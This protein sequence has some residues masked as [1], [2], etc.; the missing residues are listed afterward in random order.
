MSQ[1]V[2]VDREAPPHIPQEQLRTGILA[3]AAGLMGFGLILFIAANWDAIG[4]FERFGLVG[5]VIAAGALAS[6]ASS[7]LRI[8]GLLLATAGAGG[9]LAL[10][11][12]TYQT[13]ADPWSL[14]ALWA[15]LSLPWAVAARTDALWTPWSLIAMTAI[16]LWYASFG[17]AD[18]GWFAPNP[19]NTS[20]NIAGVP[21]TVLASWLLSL[22][23]CA[24][25][26]PSSSL[27]NW[28]GSRRWAFRLSL[29][30]TTLLIASHASAASL[31]WPMARLETYFA[32]LALLVGI[33]TWLATSAR[34]DILMIAATT[35]AV[36]VTL[37]T[38]LARLLWPS[39][40]HADFSLFILLGIAA[41]TLIAVSVVAI[42]HLVRTAPA[43]LP[44][45][46]A[47]TPAA[48][49]ETARPW[50]VVLLS[51]IGAVIAAIPF[52]AAIGTILGSSI[53]RG[54]ATYVI[55]AVVLPVSLF[56]IR[57]A[58]SLFAEQLAIV[59]LA[60]G[61]LLIGWSLFRDLPSGLAGLMCGVLSISL[62]LML[63]R[64]WLSTLLGAAAT[65]GFSI[66]IDALLPGS[67]H[68]FGNANSAVIWSVTA[69]AAVA[70][71]YAM[72]T[73]R[74]WL[75]PLGRIGVPDDTVDAALSG[76]IAASLAGLALTSGSAFLIAAHL[77]GPDGFAL[78]S[79]SQIV[80]PARLLSFAL[81]A[82][83]ALWLTNE[84]PSLQSP[85]ALTLLTTTAA[86]SIAIPALGATVLVIAFALL[87]HR[88]V[89]AAG[90]VVGVLWIIGAFYYSLAMPLTQKSALLAASGAVLAIAALAAGARL[91]RL[92]LGTSTGM[93]A[94]SSAWPRALAVVGLIA[95][96][97]L[98][99]E[100]IRAKEALIRD[101]SPVFVELVPVD[102]R[103]L[104]QG[105]YMAL[106]FQLPPE[107]TRHQ[108]TIGPA[109]FAIGKRDET[110]VFRATRIANAETLLAPDE[111]KIKLRIA[112][113]RWILVTDA[114]FFKEG[115]AHKWTA[116]RY[117][118]FRVT[119]DGSAL[120]VG[121]A[122]KDRMPI[123]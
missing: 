109:P 90:A 101:G 117:G 31:T 99:V 7:L 52:I 1:S 2:A 74:S 106:R 118:E 41:A 95:T 63:G 81:A 83:A 122:D 54:P 56:V 12:Q 84:M 35:F 27:E 89:L 50:P 44:P 87:S 21:V 88:R 78:E 104:M 79:A 71:G 11:G 25:M 62:G 28:L 97:G 22:G 13:G 9:M 33:V 100:A 6:A 29:A 39:F 85:L 69:V 75:E 20:A 92:S 116:A 114:W 115:T 64:P 108:V 26:S 107:T 68:S 3:G 43:E 48:T 110:G 47:V 121:L 34:R 113:G 8:P 65:V 111:M 123:K 18:L 82:G 42:M 58:R 15:A 19:T 38:G 14:F 67:Y 103:S 119:P 77:G 16:S 112:G 17:I 98:S 91:G 24:S 57:K 102:P 37:F 49:H 96:A 5:A 80:I 53:A 105:D 93:P 73:S 59:G 4:R 45:S 51:G 72:R 60:I 46:T 40:R 36:D 86:L 30:L 55:A 120:L 94:L 61:L 66:A 10:I 32:G 76:W 70:L 23:L